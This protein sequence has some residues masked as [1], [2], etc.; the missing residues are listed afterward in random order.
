ML[1]SV[2]ERILAQGIDV[3]FSEEVCAFLARD[4][5]DPVYGARPLRRA[6]VRRVEDSLSEAMLSGKLL[7]G[8]KV[9]AQIK[10]GEIAFEKI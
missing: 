1:E 9:T 5:F 4:G 10:D 8:D 6:I 2:R 7:A 3:T